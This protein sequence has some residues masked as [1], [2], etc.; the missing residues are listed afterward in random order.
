LTSNKFIRSAIKLCEEAALTLEERDAYERAEEQAIWEDSIKDLEDEV[1]AV[2]K[3]L[4]ESKKTIEENKKTIENKDIV[5]KEERKALEEERKALE[6]ERK[7]F[8]E[9]RKVRVGLEAELKKLKQ[10]TK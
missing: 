2:R 8:E 9:E 3:A 1:V 4:A 6:E 7:A 10:Q 5:L